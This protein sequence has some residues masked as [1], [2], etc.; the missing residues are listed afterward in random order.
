MTFENNPPQ[1]EEKQPVYDSTMQGLR[2]AAERPHLSPRY[3]FG[4]WGQTFA[5]VPSHPLGSA[6]R[7]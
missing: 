7:C 1:E 5:A 2:S 3:R 4:C 6:E